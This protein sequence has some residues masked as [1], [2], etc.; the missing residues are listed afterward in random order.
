[1]C[2]S[3]EHLSSE[4]KDSQSN[5]AEGSKWRGKRKTW[6]E[7]YFEILFIDQQPGEKDFKRK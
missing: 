1:M 7:L 4:W 3:D 2:G 6:Y 5:G